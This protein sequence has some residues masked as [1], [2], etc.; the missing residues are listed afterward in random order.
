MGNIILA[1]MIA[2]GAGTI[3]FSL[4]NWLVNEL[5]LT[6]LAQGFAAAGLPALAIQ[7]TYDLLQERSAKRALAKTALGPKIALSEF[8]IHP[9][10]AFLFSF[11]AWFG[12]VLFTGFLMGAFVGLAGDAGDFDIE[13]NPKLFAALVSYT[14]LPLRFIAAAY[15][16]RWIGTRSHP[17]VLAIVVLALVLAAIAAFYAAALIPMSDEDRKA[18]DI[19]IS[20]KRLIPIL[21]ETGIYILFAAL[22]F[23]FGQR[24]NLAFYMNFILRVLPQDTQQIIVEMAKDEA[25]RARRPATQS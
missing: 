24:Q 13:K 18:L 1:V 11:I 10:V 23:W 22:G 7:K 4:A 6:Q 21:I 15:I 17:Y 14:V 2:L 8:S 20:L 3:L 5:G 16:G 25:M 9:F 19:V 12:V